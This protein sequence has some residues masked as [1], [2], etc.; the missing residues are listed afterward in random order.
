MRGIDLVAVQ[1][2]AGVVALACLG[3]SDDERGTAGQA[4]GWDACCVDGQTTTC[5]CPAGTF[6]NFGLNTDFYADG[7]CCQGEVFCS[8]GGAAG[9]GG[10][11]GTDTGGTAGD[12]TTGGNVSGGTSGSS[13]VGGEA[14]AGYWEECCE[15]GVTSQCLCPPNVSCNFGFDVDFLPGGEC[16]YTFE[17]DAHSCNA[18]GAG[19]S[20]SAGAGG[21]GGVSP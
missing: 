9:F 12:A 1:C 10:A 4:G 16:C 3:Q 21:S 7:T 20:G 14:G 6:C 15:D 2:V 8:N 5:F 13:P 17:G 11:G 19:A 18:G